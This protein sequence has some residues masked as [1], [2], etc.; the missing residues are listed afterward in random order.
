MIKEERE[1]T[2][3]NL[4]ALAKALFCEVEI[5]NVLN[6]EVYFDGISCE[7][8]ARLVLRTQKLYERCSEL[9]CQ[10]K[11]EAISDAMCRRDRQRMRVSQRGKIHV[12]ELLA[13]LD[14]YLLLMQNGE[15]LCRYTEMLSWRDLIQSIGEEIPVSAMYAISDLAAGESERL[16]YTWSFV[17]RQN[18]EALNEILRRGISEHHM[19]LWPSVPYFQV[20]WLNLMNKPLE[21]VYMKRLLEIDK[22]EW[23][24]QQ[25]TCFSKKEFFEE[26]YMV[27][28]AGSLVTLCRQAALIRAYLCSRLKGFLPEAGQENGGNEKESGCPKGG[29]GSR[30]RWTLGWV[31]RLLNYPENI[32][33]NGDQIRNQISALRNGTRE[34]DYMLRMFRCQQMKDQEEYTVFS[35]ERWFLYSVIRDIYLT[36][37]ALCREEHNLF[38]A[39]LLI[40]IKLRT[41]MVQTDQRIGFD[42]FQRIQN[43]KG[44][45]LEDTRSKEQIARLAVREPLKHA[46]YLREMEVRIV[47]GHTAEKIRQDIQVLENAGRQGQ[48]DWCSRRDSMG[49]VPEPLWKRYY[50][51]LHFIKGQDEG[52]KRIKDSHET[53]RRLFYTECRHDRYR[54]QVEKTARAI[55]QFRERYTELA[56]RVGGID[57]CSQEIGCR[58]EVFAPVF[59]ALGEH[60]CLRED[61]GEQVPLPRLRKTYHVGEDFLDMAD[62]LRAIDEAVRFLGLDCGDRLG[63]ALALCL[64]PKEWYQAKNMQISLPV[65]DYIDN[66]A[67]LYHAVQRYHIPQQDRAVHFLEK[68]FGYYFNHV[69]RS[70][71]KEEE[72]D[73]IMYAATDFYRDD[74]EAKGYQRHSC[75]FSIDLYCRA[76]MLR[77]D[78]PDLY[79]EG[80]FK[81]LRVPVDNWERQRLNEI[82]P[83]DASI[84][85]IPEC[86]L[87]YYF[88]H[89]HEAVKY[90]G[91]E[92][93]NITVDQDYIAAVKAVQR[94]MQFDIAQRGLSVESNPTSNAKIST[95]REYS[96]HPMIAL[97][98]RG[99][100]HS[101]E[102]LR[103][104]AQVHVSI[105]TDDSGVF[106]TS[107]ESEYAV[108]ARALEEVSDESGQQRFYKWEIYEW[109]DQIRRMGNEQGFLR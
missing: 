57:A 91:T 108:M 36:Y 32:S 61:F 43:R 27:D 85:Y 19:H 105:N 59:R 87:L 93:V 97:Y 58:P 2:I 98:N 31:R 18:N 53:G 82:Y 52:L 22:K 79:R 71:L 4:C 10:K 83:P 63:H 102:E 44:Y 49:T 45:F 12:F 76:W 84:R 26:P 68:E 101:P 86:S 5:G 80:Y 40:M 38:Y 39:Y 23:S 90:A 47:P 3:E 69:Y 96:R 78:H 73:Y 48:E 17:V 1:H 33:I 15:V 75:D 94:K 21:G 60:T 92:I 77:G 104:C 25:K 81:P 89:Y 8:A 107:L 109:L 28:R 20:S 62:G 51:V 70:N 99:L 13:D 100:V 64:D 54:R 9:E 74:E 34:M 88:Y 11:M 30:G 37:P 65:Q 42:N 103:N 7:Q 24:L 95:F 14:E 72:L 41:K 67:W 50:Y 16:H 106:F 6:G 46:A 29:A 66:V 56:C 35:G 55:R